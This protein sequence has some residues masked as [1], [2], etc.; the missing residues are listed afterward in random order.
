MA[1]DMYEVR[2]IAGRGLGCIASKDIKKGSLILSENPQIPDIHNSTNNIWA[3]MEAFLQMSESDKLEYMSLHDKYDNMEVLPSYSQLLMKQELLDMKSR[4]SFIF[5]EETEKVL[6]IYRIY[7]SNCFDDGVSIKASRLNHSCNANTSFVVLDNVPDQIRAISNIKQGEEI[8]I[9]YLSASDFSMMN[10]EF[11]QA[12]LLKAWHFICSCDL[13]ENGP[14]NYGDEL[15]ELIAEAREYHKQCDEAFKEGPVDGYKHFPLELCRREL[16]CYRQIY[17]LA[18]DQ[19]LR[20]ISLFRVVERAF[21]T[22]SLGYQ[23]YKTEDLKIDCEQFAKAADKFGK[24]LGKDLVNR[25]TPD[26]WKTIYE[27]FELYMMGQPYGA[28]YFKIV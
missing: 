27:N 7:E 10:R 4:I 24:I 25:G 23:L 9:N 20:P 22:G 3:L 6:K 5:G 26:F 18:K 14:D 19:N 2:D 16:K 12:S 17:K 13:C 15:E 11:R 1:S 21:A 28:I 8:T